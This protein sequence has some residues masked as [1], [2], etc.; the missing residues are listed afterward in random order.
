MNS[1]ENISCLI[2]SLTNDDDLRQDLWVSYLDGKKPNELQEYLQSIRD[3]NA[4]DQEL[5]MSIWRLIYDPKYQHLIS[6]LEEHF[7][8]YE[9]S[10][11]CYLM[12]GLS[13]HR[14]SD[15]KGISEVRIRQS[16]SAIRYNTF[17]RDVYGIEEK[18]VGS[19]KVRAD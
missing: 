1:I 16:I 13:V 6:T 5:Q 8:D 7:T 14:I 19:R 4:D 9:R 15:L 2:N 18:P 3:E 10:I 12:L 11:L 17:W